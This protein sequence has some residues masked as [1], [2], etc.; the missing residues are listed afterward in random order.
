MY[1][2]GLRGFLNS[3]WGCGDKRYSLRTMS[4]LSGG[5]LVLHYLFLVI[6]LKCSPED[7]KYRVKDLKKLIIL[8]NAR[9]TQKTPRWTR[10]SLQHHTIG[11]PIHIYHASHEIRTLETTK[12]SRSSR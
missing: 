10:K 11:D 8:L 1:F 5:E 7:V 4:M 12:I 3:I 6:L 2:G 9:K